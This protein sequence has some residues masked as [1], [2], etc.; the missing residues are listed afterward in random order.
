MGVVRVCPALRLVC[1]PGLLRAGCRDAAL[2]GGLPP[3]EIGLGGGERLLGF[4]DGVLVALAA[5]E[6]PAQR[7]RRRGLEV[8]PLGRGDRVGQRPE[9]QGGTAAE[10]FSE[11]KLTRGSRPRDDRSRLPS[12]AARRSTASVLAAA[13]SSRAAASAA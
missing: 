11:S 9:V 12:S 6:D 13:S 8:G 3:L 1:R 2:P 5:A 7:A 4:P 10:I